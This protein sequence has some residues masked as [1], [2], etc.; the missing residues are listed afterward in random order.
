MSG[1]SGRNERVLKQIVLVMG[2]AV[3]ASVGCGA[4][5]TS[6]GNLG[7][8]TSSSGGLTGAGGGKD[9]GSGGSGGRAIISPHCWR[10]AA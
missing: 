5:S 1:W 8:A 10:G 9:R 4:R 7:G 3:A 2:G 6:E